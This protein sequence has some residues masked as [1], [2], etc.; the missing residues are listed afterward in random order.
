MPAMVHQHIAQVL[1]LDVDHRGHGVD[2]P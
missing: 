2:H 1:V